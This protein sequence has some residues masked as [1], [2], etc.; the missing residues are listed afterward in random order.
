MNK[1]IMLLISLVTCSQVMFC[2]S[3]NVEKKAGPLVIPLAE[4]SRTK[5]SKLNPVED[6]T[7]P[8]RSSA[9][10]LAPALSTA[11][12]SSKTEPITK[13]LDEMAAD[14]LIN[15][16]KNLPQSSSSSINAILPITMQHQIEGIESITDEDERFKYD[17]ESRPDEADEEG[18]ENMP[19][20]MYGYAMLRGMGWDEGK[21]I[22]LNNRGL[23]TPIEFVPRAGFR[24]GL[25]ATPKDVLPKKKKYIKPGESREPAPVMVAQPGPDGKI[26][27]VKT[28]DEKLVPLKRGL[29]AGQL[30]AIVSGPHDGLY[31]RVV[32]ARDE[33]VIVRLQASEEDVE[34]A[35]SDIT[36]VDSTKLSENHPAL[37]MMRAEKKKREKEEKSSHSSSKQTSSSYRDNEDTS[38]CWLRPRIMVRMISKSFGNGKYYNKKVNVFDVVGHN[39]CTIQLE[40]GSLVEGVKQRM[41]E[42]VIPKNGGRVMV[43][44]GP[45]KGMVG[46][47]IDRK[48][49]DKKED[50]IVQLMGDLSIKSY[51]LDDVAQYNG[52]IDDEAMEM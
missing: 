5:R 44:S 18:Y 19:I 34:V 15:D 28:I 47:L 6:Q 24:L 42:T 43:V 45:N 1:E 50:A 41:L 3:V 25:G 51:P 4:Q 46:T 39:H 8:F 23:A 11:S 22:G 49:V 14:A 29:V 13:T 30:V 12:P 20:E 32:S 37:K 27:H 17:L 21:T 52:S 26:R 31:A 36:M 10:A 33:E 35:K 16:A 40:D 7:T 38:L 9:P 2:C 48:K